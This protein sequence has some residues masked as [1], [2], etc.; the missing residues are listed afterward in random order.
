[1]SPNFVADGVVV[2]RIGA[3]SGDPGI[4]T[5]NQR[6]NAIPEFPDRPTRAG[7]GGPARTNIR[8]LRLVAVSVLL[9]VRIGP[10]LR[11]RDGEYL[12]AFFDLHIPTSYPSFPTPLAIDEFAIAD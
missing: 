1:M 3:A 8:L 6:T 11:C 9:Q 10:K 5:L 4:D 7:W 12:P 2:V